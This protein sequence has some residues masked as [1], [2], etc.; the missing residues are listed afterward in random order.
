M[1]QQQNQLRTVL[2]ALAL[3]VTG[4]LRLYPYEACTVNRLIEEFE[5]LKPLFVAEFGDGLTESQVAVLNLL[6]QD[7]LRVCL[8]HI[9]SD[10]ALR[11]S[12]MW[13]RVRLLA[14]SALL[15]FGWPLVLPPQDEPAVVVC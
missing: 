2:Q 12:G 5:D 9:C 8:E 14:R 15:A 7:L 10:V 6:H 4:Q 3:P 11:R 13:R 1:N